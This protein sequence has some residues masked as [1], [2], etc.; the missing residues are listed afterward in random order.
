MKRVIWL[1][2]ALLL[3]SDLAEDGCLGKATFL[4]PQSSAKTSVTSP[5]HDCSG[6][7]DTCY[8]LPSDGGEISRL[9]Q[10]QPVTFLIQSAL[11]MVIPTNKGGSGGIPL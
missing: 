5:L 1:L 4:P 6:K 3:L 2:L 11:K 10:C 9:T 8:P 7:V